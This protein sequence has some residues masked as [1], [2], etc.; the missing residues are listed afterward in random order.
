[1]RF[2]THRSSPVGW[3]DA[4]VEGEIADL[5]GDMQSQLAVG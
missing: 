3:A 4:E 2:V 1:M 5:R